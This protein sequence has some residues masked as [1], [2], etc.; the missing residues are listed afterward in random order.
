MRGKRVI[1]QRSKLVFGNQYYI[2]EKRSRETS[3]I[4]LD[5]EV[6][7]GIYKVIVILGVIS[8]MRKPYNSTGYIY[9]PN[10]KIYKL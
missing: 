10:Y 5:K 3:V 8:N 6:S 2:I 7:K 4:K 9:I 1:K